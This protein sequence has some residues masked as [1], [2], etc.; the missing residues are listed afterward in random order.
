MQYW[1]ATSYRGQNAYAGENPPEGAILS[2]VLGESA[3]NA[4]IEITNDDGRVVRRLDVAGEAGVI[5]RAVW[6]LRH[7]GP[8]VESSPFDG[9]PVED[10]L[11]RLPHPVTPRGPFVSPGVYT[12]TLTA[13]S[14][15]STQSIIVRGDSAMPVTVAQY[16]DREEFL[17]DIL[18][19]QHQ[20]ASLS[21]R[22][23]ELAQGL[24]SSGRENESVAD[25]IEALRSRLR[26]LRRRISSLAGQF[27]G[28]GVRQG[29]LYPPTETQRMRWQEMRAAL[30][31][32]RE[33]V[34]ELE[35]R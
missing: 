1:K 3:Q 21:D 33:A 10:A 29:S 17:L 27:N 30:A 25:S 26:Q 8:V 28:S 7:E 18:E 4:N 15:Q 16:R 9:G 2:Y 11:P 34:A 35:G 5:Y 20:V 24:S 12:A 31:R 22:V 32:E 14:A 19:G 6:D 23:G 13:G